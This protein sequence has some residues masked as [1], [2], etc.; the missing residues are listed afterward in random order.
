MNL[1]YV[2]NYLMFFGGGII[3][4]FELAPPRQK[5]F[6]KHFVLEKGRFVSKALH[7]VPLRARKKVAS[8][9]HDGK[10]RSL[11][12]STSTQRMIHLCSG[13]ANDGMI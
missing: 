13:W 2:A 10:K 11:S 1:A 5:T 7:T 9:G 12:G 3:T 8:A 6:M 4:S